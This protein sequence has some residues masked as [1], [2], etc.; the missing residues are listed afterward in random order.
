MGR[1][2]LRTLRLQRVSFGAAVPAILSSGLKPPPEFSQFWTW[3][4]QGRLTRW[5]NKEVQLRAS[6]LGSIFGFRTREW[7]R[8]QAC[9][10]TP[11]AQLEGNQVMSLA[12]VR[13]YIPSNPRTPP[14]VRTSLP[15]SHSLRVLRMFFFFSS[16]EKKPLLNSIERRLNQ[17][18]S[19]KH[20][21]AFIRKTG[22]PSPWV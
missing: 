6:G 21:A 15:K 16:W 17:R 5:P 4:L 11:R 20:F 22:F 8:S 14:P 13:W 7:A 1:G 3:R 10:A 2:Y 19:S 9:T 18:H 12:D